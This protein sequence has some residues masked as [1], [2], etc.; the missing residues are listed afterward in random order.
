MTSNKLLSVIVPSYNMEAYLAKNISSMMVEDDALRQLVEVIVVNDGSKDRTSEIAHDFAEKYPG[1]V[2]VIDKPNGHYGSC[3]NAALL[4]AKGKYVRVLDADDYADKE[5]F[6]R[7]LSFLSNVANEEELDLVISNICHVDPDGEITAQ[8]KYNLPKETSFTL[9]SIADWF[10]DFVG[11]HAITYRT[12]MLREM[13]YRQTEGCA[14]TDTE[15]FIVPMTRVRKVRYFNQV[16]MCYLVGRDGQTMQPEIFE[17]DFGVVIKIF[18]G[19]VRQWP[20]LDK[21]AVKD[22]R[23]YTQALLERKVYWLYR[24]V[25]LSKRPTHL[26][27]ALKVFDSTLKAEMPL[28]Y[29]K[30]STETT[31]S[32]KFNF[33]YV[34]VW[35]KSY[36]TK[37]VLFSLYYCYVSLRQQF[38]RLKGAK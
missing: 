27:D 35:R 20:Q 26:N 37:T 19:I 33:K 16:V 31:P 9:N 3:I 11:L 28:L 36:T 17:R 21:S 5:V 4:V 14:Y 29:E 22:G 34:K 38:H 32:R 25:L 12:S 6:E 18:E 24:F 13:N 7:F 1:C 15:W 23:R 10:T 8:T 2:T 30:C